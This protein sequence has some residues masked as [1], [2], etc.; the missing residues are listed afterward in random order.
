L[1]LFLRDA[2]RDDRRFGADQHTFAIWQKRVNFRNIEDALS[3]K[4]LLTIIAFIFACSLISLIP[5]PD[6]GFSLMAILLKEYRLRRLF[7]VSEHTQFESLSGATAILLIILV[8][9]P[10]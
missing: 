8:S 5:Y 4:I 7:R 2:Y 6:I 9:A 1:D 10:L 3:L